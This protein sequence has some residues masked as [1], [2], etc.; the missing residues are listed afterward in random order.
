MT[1]LTSAVSAVVLPPAAA[2]AQLAG[3]D[4]AD[5]PAQ[6]AASPA[7][8]LSL[9]SA[10]QL[11]LAK[12]DSKP[13]ILGDTANQKSYPVDLSTRQDELASKS[14]LTKAETAEALALNTAR[15]AREDQAFFHFSFEASYASSKPE[16]D[17]LEGQFYK[18]Y[19]GYYDSLSPQEQNS[20]RYRGSREGAV[21]AQHSFEASSKSSDDA[22]DSDLIDP[23]ELV[24]LLFEKIKTA[25]AKPDGK[26]VGKLG[27]KHKKGLQRFLEKKPEPVAQADTAKADKALPVAQSSSLT[28]RLRQSIFNRK[29]YISPLVG[30]EK[31]ANDQRSAV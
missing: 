7:V 21:A 1:S 14:T 27:K 22:A 16:S 19:V 26:A 11:V 18:A 24:L 8:I 10:A 31:P 23:K 30:S 3:A 5:R 6:R 17:H 4:T 28:P 15:N 25:G 20:Q 13:E 12:S 9:S 2:Q 29:L